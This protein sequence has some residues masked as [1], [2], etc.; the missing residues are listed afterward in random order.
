VGKFTIK[1]NADEA[2]SDNNNKNKSNT[3]KVLNAGN[4]RS[5]KAMKHLMP[6]IKAMK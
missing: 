4:N 1:G 5:N 6:E 3:N 2:L